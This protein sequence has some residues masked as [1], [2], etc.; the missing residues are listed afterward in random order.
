MNDLSPNITRQYLVPI[1][2]DL[3]RTGAIK[4]DADS[5]EEA[6]RK[7]QREMSAGILAPDAIVWDEIYAVDGSRRITGNGE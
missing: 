6:Q 5:P 3:V 7:A 1:R 2:E 4:V